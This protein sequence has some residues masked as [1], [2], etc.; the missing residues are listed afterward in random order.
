MH[1]PCRASLGGDAQKRL[2]RRV[3]RARHVSL[4]NDTEGSR[5][6]PAVALALVGNDGW[7]DARFGDAKRWRVVLNDFLRI[8]ELLL[9]PDELHAR[10][11][12]M[13]DVA[14]DE[15]RV[16][17][18]AAAKG[19]SQ[20]IVFA[21]HVPPFAEASWHEG[22]ISDIEWLPWMSSKAMGE[23]LD[24]CAGAHPAAD[25]TV[26]CGHTDSEGRFER[27]RNLTVLTG[28]AGYGTPRVCGTL[29]AK[30]G[31]CEVTPL[32]PPAAR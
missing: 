9:P 3:G 28:H 21:T 30:A 5:R 13:A 23:M 27:A 17:L 18:E 10:L 24:A 2:R 1:R 22:A 25:V 19:G 32:P 12:E 6:L 16:A 11:R 4:P 14:A 8:R 15:A 26:L 31:S 7:Y 20:R 29:V